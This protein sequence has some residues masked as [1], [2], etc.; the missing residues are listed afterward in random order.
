MVNDNH[1]FTFV[2]KDNKSLK[3]YLSITSNIITVSLS[4][5]YIKQTL[6]R[7][8][9]I[10]V[11]NIG[12]DRKKLINSKQKTFIFYDV[13]FSN[14]KDGT[15]ALL[16][17]K[18]LIFNSLYNFSNVFHYFAKR[19]TEFPITDDNFSLSEYIDLWIKTKK[20]KINSM[21]NST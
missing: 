10:E 3:I 8:D 9:I 21:Q 7:K 18:L 16:L 14:P 19:I 11:N 2:Y 6:N 5:I 15:K 13:V 17:H 20:A 1:K 12:V 4:T